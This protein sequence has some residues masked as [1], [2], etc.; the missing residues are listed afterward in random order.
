[1]TGKEIARIKTKEIQLEG[2]QPSN[3]LD[4][5]SVDI[6]KMPTAIV[7]GATGL[8]FA[9]FLASLIFVPDQ[10][11]LIFTLM[12]MV[13][14]GT[15]GAS[16]NAALRAEIMEEKMSKMGIL[17]HDRKAKGMWKTFL[18]FGHKL[19]PYAYRITGTKAKP[20]SLQDI[21]YSATNKVN[22]LPVNYILKRVNGGVAVYSEL[23]PH[24]MDNWD[25]LYFDETGR[26]INE[27]RPASEKYYKLLENPSRTEIA[28]ARISRNVNNFKNKETP[29]WLDEMANAKWK[30]PRK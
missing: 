1:M 23:L 2:I 16:V 15:A 25:K 11:D 19:F 14:G 18:P 24:P 29:L 4:T 17:G 7:S 8:G 30:S 26:N 22:V 6:I 3:F 10:L 27:S 28:T 9:G 13:F 12:S 21:R 20:K 5:Q